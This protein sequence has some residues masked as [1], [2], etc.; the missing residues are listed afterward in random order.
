MLAGE[1]MGRVLADTVVAAALP[2]K[3]SCIPVH[4][5]PERDLLGAASGTRKNERDDE[6]MLWASF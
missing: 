4:G 1:N 6:S 2:C 3:S 5:A